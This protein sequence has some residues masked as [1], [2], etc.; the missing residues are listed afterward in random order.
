MYANC[1]EGYEV[2]HIIPIKYKENGVEPTLEE[3][4]KD[5]IKQ[6]YNHYGQ[7]KTYQKEIGI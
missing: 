3:V 1:P 6:I 2:D 4:I 5:Y 7:K